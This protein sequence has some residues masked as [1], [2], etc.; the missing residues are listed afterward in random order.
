[1]NS[2]SSF[3]IARSFSCLTYAINRLTYAI[4]HLMY[5]INRLQMPSSDEACI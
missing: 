5:A 4:N 2:L 1:M 3:A